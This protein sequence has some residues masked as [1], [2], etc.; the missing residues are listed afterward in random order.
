MAARVWAAASALTEGTL[1]V[2]RRGKTRRRREVERRERDKLFSRGGNSCLTFFTREVFGIFFSG[3]KKRGDFGPCLLKWNR[4]VLDLPAG[5]LS[6]YLQSLWLFFSSSPHQT[7]SFNILLDFVAHLKMYLDTWHIHFLNP[8]YTGVEILRCIDV[9]QD[10][11][12]RAR[13]WCV[14]TDV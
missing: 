7:N 3:T 6:S 14:C 4:L 5:L 2:N 12:A 1:S 10:D 11:G 8:V 9:L 13:V